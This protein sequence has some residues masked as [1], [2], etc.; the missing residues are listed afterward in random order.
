M[1]NIAENLSEREL[2]LLRDLGRAA[3]DFDG[4]RRRALK[5]LLDAGY[6]RRCDDEAPIFALTGK[7]TQLL[8]ERGMALAEA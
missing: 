3:P 1:R 7:G 5:H 6:V 2:S 8:A 4:A